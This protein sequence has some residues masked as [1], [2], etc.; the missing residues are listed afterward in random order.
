MVR[1]QY[2]PIH[3]EWGSTNF[4]P[5]LGVYWPGQARR[6]S[7]WGGVFH[8]SCQRVRSQRP[9]AG[10][11]RTFSEE[12]LGQQTPSSVGVFVVVVVVVVV[13]VGRDK[14]SCST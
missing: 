5:T 3:F 10:K 2:I 14:N 8:R 11:R 12:T 1:F 9:R 4:Y 7:V 13:V 6:E